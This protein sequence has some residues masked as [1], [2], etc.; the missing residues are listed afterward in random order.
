[1][2]HKHQ[3][4]KYRVLLWGLN[5]VVFLVLFGI[6]EFFASTREG[7]HFILPAPSRV[8]YAFWE[9]IP[10]LAF[11]SMATLKEMGGGFAL[12]FVAAFPLAWMMAAIGPL[13]SLLQPVF[14]A[15]Q[16]IPMF[17]LA[18]LMVLWFGWSYM[19]II[20][21][22]AL[23]IFFPLTIAIYQGLCATPAPLL[24]FFRM[25][26]ATQW[27]T[28]YKLQLPWAMPHL[29]TGFRIAVAIA[30]IG[31]I[32]GEWAGAQAGLGLLMI[33]SRRAADVEIM[34]AA[35]ACLTFVSLVLYAAVA[36]LERYIARRYYRIQS[37]G[38]LAACLLLSCLALTGC[39]P[40]PEPKVTT[41]I[42]DWLPNPN[43]VAIYTGLEKGFFHDEG[44]NLKIIKVAD[45]SDTIP[46]LS[47]KQ[48]DLCVTYMPHTLQAIA[49]GAK[50]TPVGILIEVPLN[51]IIY[52][53]NDN[54]SSPD[55]LN[56]MKVGYCVDGY[57]TSFLRTMLANREIEPSAWR[58]VN[59]DLVSTLATRQVDFIYG[60]FWNIEIENLRSGGIET[61][62][63]PLSDF[64]VPNYYEL[65]FLAR[66][67]ALENDPQFL[68]AFQRGMQRSIEYARNNPEESFDI[69]LKANPDKSQQTRKWEL[70]AWH[71][72]IPTLAT[73]QDVDP[74]IWNA[75]VDW[76]IEKKLMTD[77]EEKLYIQMEGRP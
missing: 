49:R 63:F 60:A 7:L 9:H 75:F 62:Y 51:A 4:H 5:A 43:H 46:L 12:A 25:H 57:D 56:G 38:K 36:M 77:P 8:L 6:W 35:L 26:S 21:P 76:L 14:V 47:S 22:T 69:Y 71:K 19:A 44:I 33:E 23:M 11:H 72:T 24:E 15:V 17:A 42:L 2:E 27:Q 3:K 31:A 59:F 67:D 34:F 54:I 39:S 66:K 70:A 20:V 18:P 55:D 58:N 32:A 65:I 40:G 37:L 68:A 45:P 53:K 28:F 74:I 41:L 73:H 13:R 10:R 64:G 16:C 61:A 50:V 52:R 1:M 48:V 29:F 30:G